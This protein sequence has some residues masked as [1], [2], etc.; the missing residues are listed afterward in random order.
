MQVL[1]ERNVG[2]LCKYLFPNN[3]A[4]QNLSPLQKY[5]IRRIAF[6][7]SPR[8][9]VSAYTR[10][11]KTQCVAIGIAL[12][13]L[14]NRNKKIALIG[15]DKER[16]AILRNYL[17]EL[18]VDCKLLLDIADLDKTGKEKLIKEATKNRLT[19]KNGCEY[20]ILSAHGTGGALMGFGADIVVI[21]EAAMI[22][23]ESYAK[24]TRMLGDD[25]ENSVLIEMY[26]PWDRDTKAF[27]HSIAPNF[28]RIQIGYEIGI[29]EGRTT[30]AYIEEQ[31]KEI[32]PME[33]TVLYESRFP[34]EAEDSLFK[35]SDIEAAEKKVFRF[36]DELD[37]ILAKL[38]EPHKY[39]EGEIDLAKEQLKDYTKIIACDPAD[40]GLD[41][42]VIFWGIKKKNKFQ[43][44]GAYSEPKSES[45]QIVVRIMKKAKE[46][47]G[48]EVKG[49]ISV[50]E[51]G[52]GT[53]PVS[54]LK[55]IVS[56]KYEENIL[57][58]GCKGGQR[59]IK[60]DKFINMRSE[61]SFR[62]EA[63]FAEGLISFNEIVKE[64]WYRKLK[65]QL[66]AIKWT[67]TSSE[68]KQALKPE[69]KSPD[70]QDTLLYF[71]WKSNRDLAAIF[72]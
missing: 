54:R 55:E 11:G 24:I 36:Q 45:M 18:I 34:D 39:N 26:N 17:A 64:E 10:Y 68:K 41:E 72:V 37:E 13:I 50:D 58:R 60:Y 40:K 51:G 3:R 8:I 44:L 35:L 43:L 25:P 53:G 61:N 48:K 71:V 65:F 31:R 19:F 42:T 30:R 38:K 6:S 67:E 23:R 21:D 15:P 66:M 22:T 52:L 27:E 57:V 62:L 70:W 4:A 5:I 1:R 63:I 20:R 33:F 69:D 14:L 47:I 28:E 32:S 49:I 46:F 29:E 7:E 59:A 16:A 56:E 12:F 2:F 9:S